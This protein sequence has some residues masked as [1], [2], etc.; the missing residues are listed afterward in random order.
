LIRKISLLTTADENPVDQ[1]KGVVAKPIGNTLPTT[2]A[3]L[4][5]FGETNEG[6]LKAAAKLEDIMAELPVP[7]G[8]HLQARDLPLGDIIERYECRCCTPSSHIA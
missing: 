2:L 7:I 4:K 6:L 5:G 1:A 3:L 8:N